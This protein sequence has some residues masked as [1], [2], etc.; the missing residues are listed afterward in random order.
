MVVAQEEGQEEGEAERSQRV[1]HGSP[2]C[3]TLRSQAS[4]RE[5]SGQ[6]AHGGCASQQLG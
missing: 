2:S 6:S 4:A 3:S 1:P 5:V